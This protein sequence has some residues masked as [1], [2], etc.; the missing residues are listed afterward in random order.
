MIS[1]ISPVYNSETC[2]D[3]LVLAIIKSTRNVSKKIEIV[4]VDDGSTDESWKKI[5]S[6]KNKYRFIK[7]IKLKK[8]YGQHEAIFIGIKKSSFNI[9]VILDCDLQDNPKYIPQMYN[10]YQKTKKPIIIKHSYKEHSLKNRFI[11]NLFWYVLSLI[12]LKNFSP[13]FGNY[14]LI[15]KEIKKRYL[16]MSKI[17]YLYGDL[18]LQNN[19]FIFI[20]KKRPFGV[21]NKTTY[22][23]NKLVSLA[24][25]LILKYNIISR[26]FSVFNQKNIKK[27]FIEKII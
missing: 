3:K 23:L 1:I 19:E 17:G 4:L 10:E 15:D 12:S 22:N 11:S 20:E 14:L 13:Y 26:F 6:L 9:I 2:I 5:K 18:S 24:I 7:G 8:N 16:K 21:R 27:N 25:K